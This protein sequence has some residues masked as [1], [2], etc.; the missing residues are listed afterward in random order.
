M[1]QPASP[2]SQKASQKKR[3]TKP[4]RYFQVGHCPHKKQEACDFA[5]QCRYYLQGNCTNGIWCQ[6]WHGEASAGS[7]NYSGLKEYQKMSSLSDR[8]FGVSPYPLADRGGSTAVYIP[9]HFNHGIPAPW[10]E[11]VPPPH[12]L[13][14][15]P[16]IPSAASPAY[17]DSATAVRSSII[18][19]SD[20]GAPLVTY[21][22]R[23]PHYSYFSVDAQATGVPYPYAVYGD[24]FQRDSPRPQSVAPGMTPLYEIFSPETPLS[25]GFY[26]SAGF[27]PDQPSFRSADRER[28][29]VAHYRTKPCRYI[30]AGNFCRNGNDCRFIH[31]NP[32]KI[33]NEP[34]SPPPEP[35]KLQ[36]ELRPKPLFKEGN[37]RKGYFP[38][39]WRVIGGGV[40]VSGAK[41]ESSKSS[42]EDGL[43]SS[44]YS[45]DGRA[46]P[47]S[48]RALVVEIPSSAPPHTVTFPSTMDSNWYC[49]GTDHSTTDT[50]PPARQRA[51]SIPSTPIT[52]YVNHLRL[53]PAAES[54]GGL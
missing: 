50:E 11:F 14:P 51:S 49:T 43:D 8:A 27:P 47:V 54:P 28:H 33:N 4:C 39:L 30:K 29:R 7:D 23:S 1:T 21:D 25:A 53:F 12:L 42:D 37:M 34:S 22:V 10:V 41:A 35:V 16:I 38:I 36:L 44:Q 52:T 6:Y 40:L 20:D 2:S 26:A 45:F 19:V 46:E 32:D 15:H 48:R 31:A 3:H 17:M 18:S 9:S 13:P 24:P 5:H